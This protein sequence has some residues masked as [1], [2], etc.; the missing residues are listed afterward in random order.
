MNRV[1]AAYGHVCDYR[2]TGEEEAAFFNDFDE[3]GEH[4]S[5]VHFDHKMSGSNSI[6]IIMTV[7]MNHTPTITFFAQFMVIDKTALGL[8]F[9]GGFIDL[10]G[11]VPEDETKRKSI[12][13]PAEKNDRYLKLDLEL[14]GHEWCLGMN[15]MTLFF[16]REASIALSVEGSQ[17]TSLL[18]ISNISP[19][20]TNIALGRYALA[21]NTASCPSGFSRTSLIT[22][23]P[24]YQIVNLLGERLLVAQD[25]ALTSEMSIPS[26]SSIQY[27]WDDSMLPPKI[28]ICSPTGHWSRGSI[29]LDKIGVTSMRLP[30][31]ANATPMVIQVEVRMAT[32]VEDSAVVATIWMASENTNPLYLLKNDSQHSILCRQ[33]L[34]EQDSRGSD[35]FIWT[36]SPG[37]SFCFGFDEPGGLH[38][39]QWNL[40]DSARL[41]E[42]DVDAMGSTT[43]CL[44][45]DACELSCKIN[46]DQATK[47]IL[48]TESANEALSSNI[49]DG[50]NCDDD[51]D[52]IDIDFTINLSG[53]SISVID[54]VSDS[55]ELLLFLT[56]NFHI[57]FIQSR[58]GFQEALLTISTLQVDNFIFEAEHPILVSPE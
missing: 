2:P 40:M 51:N 52:I 26:H 57:H 24:R 45:P 39:L 38:V 47:V 7:E 27:H 6:D 18:N 32:K 55:R 54:N 48:F 56:E 43:S 17:W 30:C 22:I 5:I 53:I 35:S 28:H 41:F 21:Y 44:L 36:L 29:E 34:S 12:L 50:H 8:E 13:I 16:S 20:K 25:G 14:E 37:E 49:V 46:A 15:G 10:L 58:E 9:T 19:V 11:T 42:V 3:A 4:S 23:F 33:K 1:R 31:L